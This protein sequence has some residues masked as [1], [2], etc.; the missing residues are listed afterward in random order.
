VLKEYPRLLGL[1]V[2]ILGDDRK[3]TRLLAS[4][5]TNEVNQVGGK[6]ERDVIEQ[7][8]PYYGKEKALV[9]VVLPL[10]DRNGDP[11]AA[12][13]VMMNTFAGQTEQNAFARAMPIV[14]DMQNRFGSL[15][16]LI[17]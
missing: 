13:R 2:Y 6:V 16:D 14:R 1:Q 8:T 12:V 7:G 3:T 9:S 11:V 15:Q 10:R 17:Q 4:K 5:N